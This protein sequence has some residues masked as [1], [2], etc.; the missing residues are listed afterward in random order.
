MRCIYEAP[1][2]AH[3]WPESRRLMY[4]MWD[5]KSG[6]SML[7]CGTPLETAQWLDFVELILKTA[8]KKGFNPLKNC[9]KTVIG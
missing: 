5:S 6:P 8:N 2:K 1:S 4:N 3:P 9:V 7:P